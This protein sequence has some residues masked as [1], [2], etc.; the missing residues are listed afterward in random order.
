[1]TYT[2]SDEIRASVHEFLEERRWLQNL[3]SRTLSWHAHSLKM[4]AG[5]LDNPDKAKIRI[6]E[7]RQRGV[8]AISVNSYLRS[9]NA[10]WRWQKKDW[11]IPRLKEEQKI[12]A[13]F[14]QAHVA[15]LI[16]WKAVGRNQSRVRV[17]ALTAL[18]TG[19]RVNELLC[20]TRQDVELDNLVLRVKGKGNKHRLVP[21]SV[22][23]RKLLYRHLALHK[24]AIVF[25]TH[26]GCKLTQPNLRRDF[27]V[28]CEKLGII[29]V[30]C[31]FHTLRHT[32]AVGYLRAGGNLF[33]LS[34]IL[35]HTS[36]KTT[37]R[38]LQSLGVEDLQAVHDKLSLLNP[39]R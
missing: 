21:M 2:D 5:C 24:H 25:C 36:V 11:R 27:K 12:L 22:E 7:L 19:L 4:F 38:Y 14:S 28:G 8:A 26:N 31:S 3:T 6:G 29:G 9:V 10:F 34:R 39:G 33:Y 37:E 15:K 16:H 35:G 20:L 18:D 17:A 32:F 1:M 30:R 23:L 13:T